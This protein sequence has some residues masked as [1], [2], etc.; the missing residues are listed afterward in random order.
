MKK[1]LL[2]LVTLLITGFTVKAQENKLPQTVI[3][4]MESVVDRNADYIQ[5]IYKDLHAHPELPFQEVRTAG[6]VAR[7][8]NK[9]GFEVYTEIGVTG[10]A[11]VLKNGDGPV[12]M[13][14]GDMDALAI[15]EESGLPYASNQTAI[16]IDGEEVPV[17]HACGHDANTTFLISLAHTMSE[18]KDHWSGTLVLIAQ[19]AEEPITGAQAM[20]EDGLYTKYPIPQ[21]DYFLAQHTSPFPTGMFL[22]TDGRLTTGTTHVDVI[23]HGIGGHGSSPHHAIDPV[24]MA[25]Q[26]IVQLQTVVSRFTDPAEVAVLTIGSVQ[27]GVEHNVIPTQSHLKLKLH[28]STPETQDRMMKGIKSIVNGIAIAN[29]VSED[30]MPTITQEGYG[31]AIY[32]DEA[33]MSQIR[34][35]TDRVDFV[36][37]RIENMT[38]PGSEDAFVLI[39][40]VEDVKGA[41]LFIGT[42]NPELFAKARAEGKEFPFF[43]HEPNYQVDLDGITFG[44]KLA[45]LVALEVLQK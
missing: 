17:M 28:F 27:A 11:G 40:E 36:N 34:Q 15:K 41:Y 6:V 38:L 8:L 10:V 3:E 45:A 12:F 16:G 23:F 22:A 9:L 18:M 5:D 20:I 43:V 37:Q 14:R 25:G 26:A 44:S 13:Y 7:E 42:A 35:V 4:K 24:V 29:G 2:V 21:P 39:E 33:L 30:K 1:Q 31:P 19:P 32:N